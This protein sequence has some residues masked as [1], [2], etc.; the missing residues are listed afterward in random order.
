MPGSR[1]R[2]NA[3]FTGRELEVIA[4]VAEGLTDAES[5][6]RHEH[7]WTGCLDNLVAIMA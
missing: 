3:G 7:G 5:R 6:A 2:G 4:C 1:R